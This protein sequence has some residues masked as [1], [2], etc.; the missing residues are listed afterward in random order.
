MAGKIVAS[1]KK[2]VIIFVIHSSPCNFHKLQ[3]GYEED[4]DHCSQPNT[5]NNGL[6]YGYLGGQIVSY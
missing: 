5:P 6:N 2:P 3:P 4:N 1:S